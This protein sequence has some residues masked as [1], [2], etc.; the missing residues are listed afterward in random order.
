MRRRLLL[1]HCDKTSGICPR[2]GRARAL[3]HTEDTE[4]KREIYRRRCRLDWHA[5]CKI[6]DSNAGPAAST[7][8]RANVHVRQSVRP[9]EQ[10]HP[11][12]LL[13][14]SARQSDRARARRRA[15]HAMREPHTRFPLPQGERVVPPVLRDSDI[16]THRSNGGWVRH[17]LSAEARKRE[18]GS[19]VTH[20]RV[21]R[22]PLN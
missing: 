4:T 9:A 15:G 13:L 17:G 22:W 18:G 10:I 6:V 3:L 5:H 7:M 12:R 8:E 19:A 14:R 2:C 11:V 20:H 21:L 16:P 1:R